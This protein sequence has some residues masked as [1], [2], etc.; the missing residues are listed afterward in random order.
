[1]PESPLVRMLNRPGVETDADLHVLGGDLEG[2]GI[3]GRLKTLVTDLYYRED[4]DLVVNT[5][6]MLGGTER[7]APIRYWIDTGPDV[8]HFNY[9]A[10]KDTASRLRRCAR[11]RRRRLPR[12]SRSSRSRSPRTTIASARPSP[13]PSSSCVPGIM[14]SAL[15]VAGASI[16]MEVLALARGGLSRLAMDARGVEATGLAG[17][18]LRRA[19]RV[20]LGEPR[21]DPVPV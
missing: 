7:V 2:A 17:E 19:V 15:S 18:R 3:I 11:R 13:S 6:A 9:F 4:H 1:M 16:W 21:R 5:P 10:R 20:P 14:G 8:T 12:R